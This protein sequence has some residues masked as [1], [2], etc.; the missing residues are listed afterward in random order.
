[1]RDAFGVEI[2]DTV[3]DKAFSLRP[4]SNF[5]KGAKAALGG[6]K[7][8]GLG[9]AGAA[10]ASTVQRAT[11][12]G[13]GIKQAAGA[14]KVGAKNGFQS[15]KAGMP[16]IPKPTGTQMKVGGAI[17]GTGLVAG[18]AGYALGGKKEY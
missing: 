8:P 11:V 15:A 17:G 3:V 18:G 7:E 4:V 14:V 1:M 6:F 2:D 10:G 13:A 9:R 5:I 16:K 12:A